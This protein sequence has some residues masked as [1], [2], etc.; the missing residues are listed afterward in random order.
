MAKDKIE[1]KP[2]PIFIRHLLNKKPSVTKKGEGIMEKVQLV[3]EIHLVLKDKHGDLKE[4]RLIKNA[5]SAA[6]LTELCGLMLLD[7]GGTAFDYIAIGT[8]TPGATTLGG[9]AVASGSARRGGANVVGTVVSIGTGSSNGAQWVTTFTF[10]GS[11]PITEEGIF[12]APGTGAAGGDMLASQ[13]FSVLNVA[14]GD[15]LQISHKI[16]V[17]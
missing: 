9:E 11:L 13:S 16:Q 15:T 7:I 17:S 4:D 8:G 12:N 10:T 5:I 14:N 3:G 6:G 1:K 2:L